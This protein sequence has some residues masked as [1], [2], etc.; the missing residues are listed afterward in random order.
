L[1]LITHMSGWLLINY[2]FGHLPASLASV[3]LLAQPII[4]TLVA[5]PILG[6]TPKPWH[7]VGGLITLIGI[8][9]VHRSAANH[10]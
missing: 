5:L 1:G 2:A 6:E 4:T 9:T 3:T 8:Y 7:I 10:R